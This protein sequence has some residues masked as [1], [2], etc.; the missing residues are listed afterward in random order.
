MHMKTMISM[1]IA[2]TLGLAANAYA[3]CGYGPAP[4]SAEAFLH[5]IYDRYIGP[6]EKT[7]PIDYS[8]ESE[9]RRYFEP[10]LV[11]M[12]MK[13]FAAAAKVDEVPAL[14]GD[15]FVDGQEWNIPAFDIKV[16]PTDASH[17]D[18][19]IKFTNYGQ[20]KLIHV[21]LVLMNGAW[22]IHDIVWNGDEGTLRGLY[23]DQH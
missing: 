13:D 22:K 4:Q 10:S 21:Q 9:L 20:A 14:D 11:A 23:K 16:A 19:T 3:Q 18:A 2:L 6:E 1:A 7:H 15:P 5:A 17:A 12:I 8:K